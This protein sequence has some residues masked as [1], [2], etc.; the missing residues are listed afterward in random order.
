MT[1]PMKP[2]CHACQAIPQAG[3]CN[4]KGCPMLRINAARAEGGAASTDR[5]ERAAPSPL[6]RQN[7]ELLM[8]L[9][10]E[11]A[12][13]AQALSIALGALQSIQG[14]EPVT[15]EITLASVM[16]QHATDALD[17]IKA[18][19]ALATQEAGHE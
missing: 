11:R 9:R 7:A 8:A 15:H 4:L 13:C 16:A 1:E 19:A 17:D 5:E 10:A 2:F 14:M 18:L 12:R 3:Y 6:I